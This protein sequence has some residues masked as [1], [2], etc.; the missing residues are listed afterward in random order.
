[1]KNIKKIAS[2]ILAMTLPRQDIQYTKATLVKLW[3][4]LGIPGGLKEDLKNVIKYLN[5]LAT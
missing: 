3:K 5:D 4:T 2:E 1:M